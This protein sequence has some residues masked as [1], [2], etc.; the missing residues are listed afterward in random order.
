MLLL[1][2]GCTTTLTAPVTSSRGEASG[3]AVAPAIRHYPLALGEI[4]TGGVPTQQPVPDYPPALLQRCPALVELQAALM[5][6]VDGTVSVVRIDGEAHGDAQLRTF[7]EALREAV[8]H[9]RFTPLSVSRWAADA[10]G[11]S[12]EVDTGAQAFSQSYVFR[13]E[14]HEGRS[15][16]SV[17]AAVQPVKP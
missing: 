15:M 1:L 4:S 13:F 12:H 6:D 7:A 10:D 8:S 3:R 9:W 17:K 11:N 2:E 5:V 16:V 14:C